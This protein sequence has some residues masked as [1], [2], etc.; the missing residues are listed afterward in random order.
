MSLLGRYLAA[1]HPATPERWLVNWFTGPTS[2]TGLA[3]STDTAQRLTAV[4]A[5]LRIIAETESCLPLPLYRKRASGGKDRADDH[6]L[7][8]ILRYQA[9]PWQTA[10]EFRRLMTWHAAAG[11]AAYAH[12][13]TRGDGRIAALVPLLPSRTRPD[14]LEDGRIVYRYQPAKGPERVFAFEEV[15]KLLPFTEDGVTPRSLIEVCQEAI[16]VALSAEDFVARF[17]GNSAVPGGVLTHPLR[18]NKDSADRIR[19]EWKKRFGGE[20]TGSIAVL[21]EGMKY[22]SIGMPLKD[23]QFLE[24]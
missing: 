1:S 24:S 4:T 5:A 7:Y 13:V 14:V 17:Y 22:E 6:P 8:R 15:F 21:E 16:G 10:M 18:L 20:K 12:I 23:A 9:N 3:V 19:T 11:G 2:G